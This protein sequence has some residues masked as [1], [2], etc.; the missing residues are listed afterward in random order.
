MTENI[1]LG[2]VDDKFI[3]FVNESYLLTVTLLQDPDV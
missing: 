3:S 1:T 2:A